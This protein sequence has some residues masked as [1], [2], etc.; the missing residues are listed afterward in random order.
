MLVWKKNHG[1]IWEEALRPSSSNLPARDKD[2]KKQR[3]RLVNSNQ[4]GD[5]ENAQTKYFI[6]TVNSQCVCAHTYL[7]EWS[8]G[9]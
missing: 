8:S 2:T 7:C 6:V 1:I 9:S 4:N 3:H 5:E